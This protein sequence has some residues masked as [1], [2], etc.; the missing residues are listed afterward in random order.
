MPTRNWDSLD[1]ISKSGDQVRV[2]RL[3]RKVDT[4][5]WRLLVVD[6][7]GYWINL[8]PVDRALGFH[9]TYLLDSD[10]ATG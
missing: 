10:L 3:V 6:T 9:N 8:Y 1:D 7:G 5:Y 4:G 2:V